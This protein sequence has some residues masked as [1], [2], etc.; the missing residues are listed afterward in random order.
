MH[1]CIVQ[2]CGDGHAY[3]C[4]RHAWGSRGEVG[5]IGAVFIGAVLVQ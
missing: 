4:S 3:W 5:S 1:A 2:C